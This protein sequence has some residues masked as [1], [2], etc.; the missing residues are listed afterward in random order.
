VRSRGGASGSTGERDA[1]REKAAKKNE[2][3]EQWSQRKAP[4]WY[5][6]HRANTGAKFAFRKSWGLAKPVHKNLRFFSNFFLPE[7]QQLSGT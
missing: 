7:N 1:G 2:D 5:Q 4:D 3:G 6:N